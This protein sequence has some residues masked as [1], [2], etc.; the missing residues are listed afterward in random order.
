M[1]KSPR[2]AVEKARQRPWTVTRKTSEKGATWTHWV[3]FSVGPPRSFRPSCTAILRGR[4]LSSRH[5]DHW[6]SGVPASFFRSLTKLLPHVA[7]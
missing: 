2:Q 4:I 3:P 7:W 1:S 6:I 5:A